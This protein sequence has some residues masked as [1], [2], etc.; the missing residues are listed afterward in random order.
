[1]PICVFKNF[2]FKYLCESLQNEGT[3]STLESVS[4]IT[5]KWY[6]MIICCFINLYE[7]GV[8]VAHYYTCANK[9]GLDLCDCLRLVLVLTF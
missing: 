7:F 5:R 6:Q 4:K 1:M 8:S 2:C 3:S 9:C